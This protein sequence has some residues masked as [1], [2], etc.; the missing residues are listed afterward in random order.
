MLRM[1]RYGLEGKGGIMSTRRQPPATLPVLM[2]MRQR[3]SERC[4]EK[5][6]ASEM[7]RLNDL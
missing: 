6:F 1:A 4:S 3:R 5:E 7:H 2:A